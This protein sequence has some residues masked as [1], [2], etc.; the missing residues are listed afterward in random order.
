MKI[1]GGSLG[2][3]AFAREIDEL[4]KERSTA[5]GT[6]PTYFLNAEVEKMP[7][8]ISSYGWNF[9]RKVEIHRKAGE[10]ERREF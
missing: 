2:E 4:M 10:D 6:V 5:V 3:G 7:D 9:G 8:E 1:Y